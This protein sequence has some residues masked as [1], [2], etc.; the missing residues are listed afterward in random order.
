[1][2]K[3]KIK[4][5]KLKASQR[6]NRRYLLIN[7]NSEEIEKAILDY[8]GVLGYAKSAY[9]K[10]KEDNEKVIVGVLR[11]SLNDVKASLALAGISVE[12][13]SGTLKGLGYN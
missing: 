5:A 4:K 3:K 8:I 12:R 1:M 9:M 2:K 7:S 13:V 10:V 11:E 6:D